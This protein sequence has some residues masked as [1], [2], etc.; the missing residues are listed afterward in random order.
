MTTP[1]ALKG[2][3]VALG[4]NAADVAG[5]VLTV[6]VLNAISGK[7]GGETTAVTI[8]E[9]IQAITAVAGEIGKE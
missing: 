4:G 9:A 7:Y 5:K 8:P 6:E 1:E 3:Y 2:L